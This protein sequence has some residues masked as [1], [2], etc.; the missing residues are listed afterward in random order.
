MADIVG[1]CWQ[2]VYSLY[3]Y[4]RSSLIILQHD[5]R[6]AEDARISKGQGSGETY[7]LLELT[8]RSQW[9]CAKTVKDLRFD[10]DTNG[11]Q[12]CKLVVVAE[13]WQPKMLKVKQVMV[14]WFQAQGLGRILQDEGWLHRKT[15]IPEP[16]FRPDSIWH[17]LGAGHCVEEGAYRHQVEIED[18]PYTSSVM[19][20]LIPDGTA[21]LI[22]HMGELWVSACLLLN[23][24]RAQGPG[25]T[26]L[27]GKSTGHYSCGSR[28]VRT[29]KVNPS[30]S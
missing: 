25:R 2:A 3:N 19:L 13:Y 17:S 4:S 15:S 7:L 5:L 20:S 12:W 21:N 27:Q 1:W 26:H 8:I 22:L 24:R 16:V 29:D 23:S 18:L 28:K 14:L 10:L 30:R 9:I 11:N 6:V